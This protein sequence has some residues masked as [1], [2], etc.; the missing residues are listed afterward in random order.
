[1]P[2]AQL[3]FAG[4]IAGAVIADVPE[5]SGERRVDQWQHGRIGCDAVT[6]RLSMRVKS[7]TEN[8]LHANMRSAKISK[9]R[10][11]KKV[12]GQ[13]KR[14]SEGGL[15]GP[16]RKRRAIGSSAG[17][18]LAARTDSIATFLSRLTAADAELKKRIE[19]LVSSP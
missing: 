1:M 3:G 9:L 18:A 14:S 5:P 11:F 6:M 13:L 12:Q 15:E 17:V 19:G 4:L 7:P 2:A 8:W 10:A 16:I